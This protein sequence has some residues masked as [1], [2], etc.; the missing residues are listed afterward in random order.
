M[1]WAYVDVFRLLGY[2]ALVCIPITFLF[3][4]VKLE[5]G[6]ITAH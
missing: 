3:K 2:L 4:K 6:P 5:K 1:L